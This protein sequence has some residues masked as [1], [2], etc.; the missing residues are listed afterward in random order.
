[1]EKMEKKESGSTDEK[2][3]DCKQEEFDPDKLE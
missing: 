2:M 1:V 3:E